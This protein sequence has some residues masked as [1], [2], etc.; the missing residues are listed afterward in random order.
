MWITEH[1]N[2][3][4]KVEKCKCVA[5]VIKTEERLQYTGG[6]YSGTTVRCYIS[7]VC[8]D[9]THDQG[10]EDV[11]KSEI[12]S[13]RMK[14]VNKMINEGYTLISTEAVKMEKWIDV[15][16]RHILCK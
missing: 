7:L 12:T 4:I 9:R 10:R 6:S 2:K 14:L 1:R 15:E 8:D 5:L 13:Y 11:E 3:E 16:Y